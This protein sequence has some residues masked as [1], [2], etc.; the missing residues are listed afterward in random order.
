[1][2]ELSEKVAA[3]EKVASDALAELAVL[4]SRPTHPLLVQPESGKQYYTIDQCGSIFAIAAWDSYLNMCKKTAKQGRLFTTKQKAETFGKREAAIAT[5]N[6]AILMANGG[7]VLDWDVLKICKFLPV[8]EHD[9][10]E[11]KVMLYNALQS[12]FTFYACHDAPAL[13]K[14]IS[15]HAE[16]F[17]AVL[18]T[19]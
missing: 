5:I 9:S 2:S 10:K 13:R 4:K 3:L 18:D 7:S 8:F 19:D 12:N 16:E 1:M 6:R 15:D 17:S 11:W 14:I